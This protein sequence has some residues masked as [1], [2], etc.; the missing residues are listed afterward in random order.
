LQKAETRLHQLDT[1]IK[2]LE[3]G[4][5]ENIIHMIRNQSSMDEG[6][7]VDWLMKKLKI[8]DLQAKFVLHTEIGR[9]SKGHLNKYKEE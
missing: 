3:S 1:Y 5:V 8:T 9:L 2:I 4:D 6:Y 7:L